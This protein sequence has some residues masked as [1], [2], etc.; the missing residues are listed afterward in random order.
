MQAWASWRVAA[1][2]DLHSSEKSKQLQFRIKRRQ[3]LTVRNAE[4]RCILHMRKH[5]V[6]HIVFY[7]T[8]IVRYAF[9]LGAFTQRYKAHDVSSKAYKYRSKA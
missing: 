8:R 9:V 4:G 7:R 1:Y 3:P 2:C 6:Q 5:M